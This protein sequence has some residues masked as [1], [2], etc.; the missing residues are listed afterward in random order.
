LD[1]DCELLAAQPSIMPLLHRNAIRPEQV[2]EVLR[3]DTENE[4][5]AFVKLWDTLTPATRSIA[6]LEALAMA[7]ELTPR[8][9]WELFSGASM[10]QSRESVAT[11]IAL[12]LPEVFRTTIRGAKKAKGH[13]DREH[14]Y[15]IS[16]S[17]PTPKGSVTNINLGKKAEELSDGDEPDEKPLEESDQFIMRTADAMYIKALPAPVDEAEDAEEIE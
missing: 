6:G 12:A 9:L 2:V 13:L 1:V 10:V 14:L 3:C 15:K 16:G 4:S 7:A 11:M 17:L 5:Q 8:R